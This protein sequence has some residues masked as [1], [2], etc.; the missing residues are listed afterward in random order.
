LFCIIVF[1]SVA[2][3]VTNGCDGKTSNKHPV[4]SAEPQL[5]N[6]TENGQKFLMQNGTSYV[7]LLNLTGSPYEMGVAYG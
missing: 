5:L 6:T 1:F 2:V 7:Y 3:S 4:L